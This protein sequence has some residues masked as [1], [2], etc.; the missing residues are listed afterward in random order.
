M[1]TTKVTMTQIGDSRWRAKVIDDAVADGDQGE[2]DVSQFIKHS[3]WVEIAGGTGVVTP[4]WSPDGGTTWI[5]TT[6]ISAS[7]LYDTELMATNLKFVTSS[8]SSATYNAWWIGRKI[9]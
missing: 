9:R 4:Y 1:A 6:P 8:T 5:A 3:I 2:I 7:G